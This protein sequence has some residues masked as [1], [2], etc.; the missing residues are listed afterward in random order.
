MK[1]I[2]ELERVESSGESHVMAVEQTQN[3]EE[4]CL[5]DLEMLALREVSFK[6]LGKADEDSSDKLI[7]N[8]ETKVKNSE[9]SELYYE[10]CALLALST[11]SCFVLSV[12]SILMR[13]AVSVGSS[14]LGLTE[15]SINVGAGITN[16][17]FGLFGFSLAG[18]VMG[19]PFLFILLDLKNEVHGWFGSFVGRE[20]K[21]ANLFYSMFNVNI[22]EKEL[23][24]KKVKIY[25]VV[26]YMKEYILN[27]LNGEEYKD[28][29]RLEMEKEHSSAE[30][31]VKEASEPERKEKTKIK[32]ENRFGKCSAYLET[33]NVFNKEEFEKNFREELSRAL[34]EQD[35][36]VTKKIEALHWKF[37]ELT[38]PAC[39][40]SES[41]R[42]KALQRNLVEHTVVYFSV[43]TYMEETKEKMRLEELKK[44]KKKDVAG[45]SIV[46]GVNVDD[47]KI[48]AE[49]MEASL[50][51]NKDYRSELFKVLGDK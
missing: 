49:N 51:S 30:K 10:G 40:L 41:K 38:S 43:F 18:L 44:K 5:K 28:F 23:F 42:V 20:G 1:A 2:K 14:L 46:G 12:A 17:F 29:R 3:L 36:E 34:L 6:V 19:M 15:V 25:G 22:K 33:P 45:E 32:I 39:E 26:S 27:T 7:I 16:I 47:L 24:S 8:K 50:K 37:L 9:M 48:H 35:N 13:I 21:N 4:S 11:L 31:N